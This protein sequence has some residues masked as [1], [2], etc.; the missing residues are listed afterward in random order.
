[1]IPSVGFDFDSCIANAYSITPFVIILERLVPSILSKQPSLKNEMVFL[2]KSRLIFYQKLAENEIAT[3]GTILRPSI[4]RLLPKLLELKQQ[5]NLRQLF[6][7]SNN[8]SAEIIHVVD[9]IMA[10]VLNKAPYNVPDQQLVKDTDG[11]L[12]TLSPRFHLDAPCRSVEVKDST[13]FREKS[14]DGINACLGESI[15]PT[16]LWYL[17]DTRYHAK[18]MNQIKENYLVVE[19]YNVQLSNKRIAEIFIESYPADAFKPN[20]RIGNVLLTEINRLMPGFR[21]TGFETRERLMEKL[22]KV[23]NA[24]SPD[25]GGKVFSRWKED[26]VNKDY[27][28]LEQG[29]NGAMN[30][31]K[32]NTINDMNKPLTYKNPIGGSLTKKGRKTRR[33]RKRRYF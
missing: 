21:P 9:H 5:G 6:I 24:F 11:F 25:S 32:A 19:P 18:L 8:S 26:H 20:T 14:L 23:L 3:K 1:M 22:V 15:A 13:G 33:I 30:P 2:Q 10:L 28:L 4:L 16:D 17:D 29:L 12:H 31:M 7:Y 27:K